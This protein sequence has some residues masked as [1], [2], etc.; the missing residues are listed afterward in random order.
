MFD[1]V[2]WANARVL[3]LLTTT[4]S[5]STPHVLRWIA[6]VI[7][8]E[9]VWLLRLQHDVNAGA[10][11]I[12]PDWSIDDVRRI[13]ADNARDFETMFETL[14]DTDLAR[15]IEY[16]NSQGKTFRTGLGDI[17]TH[18]ARTNRRGHS[19]RR[20]RARRHRLHHVRAGALRR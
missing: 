15:V 13:A 9:R 8:A 16:R 3:D 1:H 14:A 4:P 2:A 7:A 12:W 19:R 6:H 20:D 18:I 10:H 5:A 17:L 11:P